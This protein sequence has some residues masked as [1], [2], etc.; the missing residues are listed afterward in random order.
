MAKDLKSQILERVEQRLKK[1]RISARAASLAAG[2]SADIIR[3]WQNKPAL[4]RI[5]TLAQM[6]RALDVTPE[7]LTFGVGEDVTQTIPLISWVSAGGMSLADTVQDV[8]DARRIVVADLPDGDWVALKVEGDS[9][10]RISPP[11]ST[12]V[13]NRRDKKLVAN[14][15]YIFHDV[16]GSASYK[17]YRP[18]PDRFEPVSTNPVHQPLFPDPG[19]MPAIFGRVG[20]TLLD[21]Y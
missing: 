9:M 1:L 17:R 12:I 8:E 20:R 18:S 6:A 21:L 16:D 19:N 11:D 13:I 5:D 10:D 4:P 15:C 7:W 14:G 2:G 3:N